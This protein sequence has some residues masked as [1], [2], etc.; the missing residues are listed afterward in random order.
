MRTLTELQQSAESNGSYLEL[1][2]VTQEE[3]DN[4]VKEGAKLCA[5]GNNEWLV[6]YYFKEGHDLPYA[7]QQLVIK[8]KEIK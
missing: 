2:N 3:I 4:A 5:N 6:V 1:L 8:T 7:S